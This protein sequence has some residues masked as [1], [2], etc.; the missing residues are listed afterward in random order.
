MHTSLIW[1]KSAYVWIILNVIVFVGEGEQKE[2]VQDVE[3]QDV[4]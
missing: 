4:S 3:D 1:M 2:Q